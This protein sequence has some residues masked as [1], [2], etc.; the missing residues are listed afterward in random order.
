MYPSPTTGPVQ[1][2]SEITGHMTVEVYNT[3]GTLVQT[4]SFNG[5]ETSLDL[6]GNAAGIYTIRV[7]DGTNYNVQRIALK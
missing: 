4:A 5:T 3:L 6:S 7:G 1:I 2:R